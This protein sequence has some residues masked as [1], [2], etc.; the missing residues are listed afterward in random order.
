VEGLTVDAAEDLAERCLDAC[1]LAVR[2]GDASGLAELLTADAVIEVAELRTEWLRGAE[3]LAE[4]LA[5]LTHGGMVL[6]D[7]SA[8]GPDVVAGVAW[9]DDPTVRTAEVRLVPDGDRISRLEW[10]R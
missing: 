8:V 6:L 9:D 1:N 10:V 4:R 3:E 5:E 2:D 7:V